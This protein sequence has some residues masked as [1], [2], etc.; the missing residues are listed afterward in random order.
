MA[1]LPKSKQQN[2]AQNILANDIRDQYNH[3]W[4]YVCD[5]SNKMN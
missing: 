2:G 3:L 1:S 5:I 4:D